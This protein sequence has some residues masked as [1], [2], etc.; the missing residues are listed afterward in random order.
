MEGEKVIIDNSSSSE[1]SVHSISILL[2]DSDLTSLSIV[3]A[4]LK[5]FNY[6]GVCIYIHIHTYIFFILFVKIILHTRLFF[7]YALEMGLLSCFQVDLTPFF[8]IC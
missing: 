8:L 3:A 2:V 7:I 4:M 6:Q 1:E 5:K